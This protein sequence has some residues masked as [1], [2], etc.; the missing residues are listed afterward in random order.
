MTPACTPGRRG[1]LIAIIDDEV[2]ITTYLQ[3]A[4][5]D[6]GLRVVTTNDANHA[7]EL[8]ERFLPDLVCLDLLMP[9]QTGLSLYAQIVVHPT[10]RHLPIVILS[11]LANADELPR[12]LEQSGR[13]PAP[14]SYVEK[15][16][17]AATLL[18]TVNVLLRRPA[19]V[20]P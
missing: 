2:D 3:M 14:A 6:S 19:G 16:V 11:G 13:L 17:D 12:L 18:R 10:L 4:L 5:E 8:L 7:I 1:P 20:T 9:E 15:P